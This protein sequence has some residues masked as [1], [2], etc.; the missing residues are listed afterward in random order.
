VARRP[1]LTLAVIA[2]VFTLAQHWPALQVQF[3]VDEFSELRPWTQAEIWQS[4]TG[5]WDPSGASEPYYRP[6]AALYYAASFEVFGFNPAPLHAISL[7]LTTAAAW[8]LGLFAWRETG[9]L[10]VGIAATVLFVLHPALPDAALA[11]TKLHPSLIGCAVTAACLLIWQRVRTEPLGAWWPIWLLVLFYAGFKEDAVM[12]AP[13]LVAIQWIHARWWNGPR[14]RP[15]VVAVAVLLP[16]VVTLLRV[17]VV[18]AQGLSLT[19]QSL[20]QEGLYGPY[21]T[22]VRVLVTAPIHSQFAVHWPSTLVVTTLT[23][24]GVAGLLRDRSHPASRLFLS[25][26]VLMA[27]LGAPLA[28]ISGP[29]RVHLVVLSAAV[30]LSGAGGLLW[31]HISSTMGR[32]VV[33][34]LATLALATGSRHNLDAFAPCASFEPE[35]TAAALSLPRIPPD[36]RGFLEGRERA[37][38]AGDARSPLAALGILRWPNTDHTVV[39]VAEHAIPQGLVVTHP[40]GRTESITLPVSPAWRRWLMRGDRVTIHHEPAGVVVSL[41]DQSQ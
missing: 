26:L 5:P 4:L 28:L 33:V 29:T 21:H 10:C 27:V 16:I 9:R 34:T 18:P 30:A 15:G 14:I 17:S 20:L 12:I 41:G 32:A 35:G 22:L 6:L 8:L 25:G 11:P 40:D 1:A 36:L 23:S 31:D 2:A 37:C 3:W 13:A 24:I 39:L 38:E 19:L 7:L